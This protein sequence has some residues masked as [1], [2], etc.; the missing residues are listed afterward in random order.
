MARKYKEI[1]RS[2]KIF[3]CDLFN[4]T[5][6]LKYKT[7]LPSIA[8]KI[9]GAESAIKQVY[10]LLLNKIQFL[11]KRARIKINTININKCCMNYKQLHID[12]FFLIF[13]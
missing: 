2:M 10:C 3:L 8:S 5:T 6:Y 4:F 1:V 11:T 13:S 9:K 12:F 7:K